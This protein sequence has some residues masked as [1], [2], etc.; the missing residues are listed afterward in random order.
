MALYLHSP[1]HLHAIVLKH[2]LVIITIADNAAAA[3]NISRVTPNEMRK[4]IIYFLQD[5]ST[6]YDL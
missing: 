5:F 3:K 4:S 2:R 6:D 1:K